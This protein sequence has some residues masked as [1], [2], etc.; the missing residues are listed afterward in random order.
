MDSPQSRTMMPIE[1]PSIVPLT[2][3][4]ATACHPAAALKFTAWLIAATLLLPG[5]ARAAA[6]LE[7]G[8]PPY[9]S[10]RTL[11]SLFKPLANHI[12]QRLRQPVML[13]TAPSV[14]QFDERLQ[15]S[16]YDLAIASPH[17]VRR[18]QRDQLYEPLLRFTVDLY[19]VLL[20]RADSPYQTLRDLAGQS[21]AFPP[22]ATATFLLGKE[23]LDRHGVGG[24]RL[25]ESN[26]FQDTLFMGLLHGDYPAALVN[27][28]VLNGASAADRAKV[29][30]IAQTRR[31][32][33]MMLVA[34][35]SLPRTER[36]HIAQAVIDFMERTPEGAQFLQDTGL[37]GVR[38][39]SELELRTLDTLAAEQRKLW[40]EQRP[41]TRPSR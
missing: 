10:T 29:R 5:F 16:Q 36:E 3:G 4:S 25:I 13:V 32:P 12:E 7:F 6:P 24:A 8:L 26:G 28:F 30:Q 40:E 9:I 41:A 23:L 21:I 33:H 2:G 39:P 20:V 31:V 11:M 19:G 14:M 35:T 18:A 15:D 37:G 1:D 22:R 34:R 17:T 38:P 27:P